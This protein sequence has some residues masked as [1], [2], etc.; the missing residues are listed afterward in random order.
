M[1]TSPNIF[2]IVFSYKTPTNLQV[3]NLMSKAR[4]YTSI[5]NT[6][7]EILVWQI[8][9]PIHH[10]M[11][12]STTFPGQRLR[13]TQPGQVPMATATLTPKDHTTSVV[14]TEGEDLPIQVSTKYFIYLSD[15]RLLLIP[16]YPVTGSGWRVP[17]PSFKL[18]VVVLFCFFNAR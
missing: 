3:T 16:W 12:E 8:P 1:T 15:L 9:P 17:A 18:S 5:M 4:N 13:S 14:L 11:P 10:L 6:R 2:K 7:L